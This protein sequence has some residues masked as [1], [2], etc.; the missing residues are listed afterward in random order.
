[1]LLSASGL[2]TAAL[3]S[4]ENQDFGFSQNRRMVANI[5]PRAA[6]YRL[7]QLTL[8]HARIQESLARIPG[9]SAV[10]LC[11]YSP[12]SGGN[13]GGSIWA[14]G[15]PP[16]GPRD[17]NPASMNRVTAGYTSSTC[18]LPDS[19]SRSCNSCRSRSDRLLHNGSGSLHGKNGLRCSRPARSGHCDW[20]GSGARRYG[21][22]NVTGPAIRYFRGRD[23]VE[24]H[25]GG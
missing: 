10:A 17:D 3:H 16:P 12:L 11:K 25:R 7:E 6:G 5:N 24:L 13:W 8:L 19:C 20:A 1:V 2:L 23:S 14:D 22:P 4:L 18:R 15:H 21:R 9:V